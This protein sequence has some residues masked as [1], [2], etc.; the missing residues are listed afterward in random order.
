MSTNVRHPHHRIAELL[1]MLPVAKFG[2]LVAT[3]LDGELM[4]DVIVA[5]RD[6]YLPY[7]VW[8]WVLVVSDE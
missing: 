3:A 1:D 7:V 5:L 8:G 4:G 2:D 6:A